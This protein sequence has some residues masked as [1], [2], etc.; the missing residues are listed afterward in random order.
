M[1]DLALSVVVPSFRGAARLA[2]LLD[3]LRSQVIDE[4]WEA[5]IVLD[6]VVD[7]S[8]AVIER[9]RGDLPI[10]IVELATNQG[11]PAALNAGFAAARGQVLV[12]CDDDLGLAPG[13]LAGHLAAHVRASAKGDTIG[14]IGLCRDLLPD[15]PYARAYGRPANERA[16]AAGYRARPDE[17]W[18]HWAANCSVTRATFALVGDYDERFTGYGWED[19]D[20]GYR[21]HR[22]GVDVLIDPSLEVLHRAAGTNVAVR[23]HRA[24]LG[25]R[26]RARFDTKHGLDPLV[27]TA[28]GAAQRM[29]RRAV[30]S[31]ARIGSETTFET[32]GA[33][34]D[35]ILSATP[36]AIRG[37]LIAFLVEAAADAGYDDFA[38]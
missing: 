27:A 31:A 18:R 33:R 19:V 15:S 3:G 14:L 13:F 8:V 34:V 29:W 28:D 25:G 7:D 26:A 21:L 2:S 30:R 23:V 10:R 6:G 38:G 32:W 12:R 20:W 24:Y 4:T 5:V 11:R 17:T 35:R 9:H 16:R 1:T 37:P 22:S 36:D